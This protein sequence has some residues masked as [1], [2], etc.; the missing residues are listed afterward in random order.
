MLSPE[1][2]IRVRR[3]SDV[4]S[5]LSLPE[6]ARSLVSSVNDSVGERVV[7]IRNNN[8]YYSLKEI[9]GA[10][11]VHGFVGWSDRHFLKIDEPFP[12]M[13]IP[14]EIG[15]TGIML[16]SGERVSPHDERLGV[17][18]RDLLMGHRIT[19]AIYQAESGKIDNYSK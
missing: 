13:M 6:D 11:L 16:S 5:G 3:K 9:G 7:Y 15:D 17:I 14:I 2:F 19:E 10:V 1:H 18:D 12:E 4:Q 8:R